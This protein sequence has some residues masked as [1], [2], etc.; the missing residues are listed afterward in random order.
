MF[1][2]QHLFFKPCFSRNFRTIEDLSFYI[3]ERKRQKYIGKII[4]EFLL[5]VFIIEEKSDLF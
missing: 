5:I 3:F 2:R 4:N 1:L